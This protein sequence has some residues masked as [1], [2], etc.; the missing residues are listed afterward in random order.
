MAVPLLVAFRGLLRTGEM[1]A[2]QPSRLVVRTRTGPSSVCTR[3][4][5]ADRSFVAPICD[6]IFAKQRLYA[7]NGYLFRS[8]VSVSRPQIASPNARRQPY[9]FRRGWQQPIFREIGSLDR[10][11]V[12]GRWKSTSTVAGLRPAFVEPVEV[13]Q[14]VEWSR[15]LAGQRRSHRL[16][17]SNTLRKSVLSEREEHNNIHVFISTTH[18]SCFSDMFVALLSSLYCCEEVEPG[19]KHA[20]PWCAEK[21]ISVVTLCSGSSSISH[22]LAAQSHSQHFPPHLHC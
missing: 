2:T 7:H 12:R 13:L 16:M 22:I 11:A 18:R 5:H 21:H 1:L 19:W 15:S 8:Q 9:R 14:E 10:T 4:C 6:N 3:D 17:E 20:S